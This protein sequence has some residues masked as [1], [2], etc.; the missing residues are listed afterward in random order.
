M[1]NLVLKHISH[2]SL[3]FEYDQVKAI[4]HLS[5][6]KNLTKNILS[7][8]HFNHYSGKLFFNK[9]YMTYM[10]EIKQF[11]FKNQQLSKKQIVKN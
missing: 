4:D 9:T 5:K 1:L 7:Y 2:I 8:I 11:L 6:V 3:Y 10:F